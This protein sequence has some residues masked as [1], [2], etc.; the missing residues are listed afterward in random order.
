M[1]SELTPGSVESAEGDSKLGNQFKVPAEEVKLFSEELPS[2]PSVPQQD[3]VL[4]PDGL[5]LI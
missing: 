5:S 3:L 1:G 4:R 2:N